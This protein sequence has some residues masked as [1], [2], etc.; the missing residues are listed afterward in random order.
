[1]HCKYN[2]YNVCTGRENSLVSLAKIIQEHSG[3]FNK[4]IIAE[5]GRGSEKGRGREYSGDNSR[6]MNELG[7]YSYTPITESII[8]L[9]NWYNT[10]KDLINVNILKGIKNG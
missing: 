7:G 6:L 1:M 8:K 4:I 9:Y 3:K 2:V 5:K 10:N